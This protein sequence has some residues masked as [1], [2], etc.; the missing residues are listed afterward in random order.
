[1]RTADPERFFRAEQ[2]QIFFDLGTELEF[3]LTMGA[4]GD[5]ILISFP[6]CL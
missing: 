5:H 1:L 3:F 2:A 4:G 6:V